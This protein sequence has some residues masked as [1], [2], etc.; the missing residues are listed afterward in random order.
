MYCTCNLTGCSKCKSLNEVSFRR[1]SQIRS[2]RTFAP[3][4][5]F[6]H[7]GPGTSRSDKVGRSVGPLSTLR[8]PHAVSDIQAFERLTERASDALHS[9][10]VREFGT[11]AVVGGLNVENVSFEEVDD[12]KPVDTASG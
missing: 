12:Y 2:C 9:R 11:S 6:G 8:P 1:R 10:H 4:S 7:G 5:G 3:S